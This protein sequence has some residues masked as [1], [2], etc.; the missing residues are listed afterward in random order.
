MKKAFTLA[1]LLVVLA[2]LGVIAAIVTPVVFD[3]MPNE[4]M[5][6]FKKAYYTFEKA[7]QTL[8]NDTNLYPEV[9]VFTNSNQDYF[10]NNL[11]NLLNTASLG[12]NNPSNCSGST[13]TM[14]TASAL[15]DGSP[16]DP[17]P[18]NPN[19]EATGGTCGD[20]N[21]ATPAFITSDGV[22]WWGLRSTFNPDKSYYTVVCI[23]VDGKG[24][25]TAI[26]VGLRYDGK[27]RL[28][29]RASNYLRGNGNNL[30]ME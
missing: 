4:N 16:A 6:R 20:A 5:I 17:T 3:A 24:G 18:E 23:D 11:A 15:N 21:S 7:V 19:P 29:N 8:A 25:E 27:I 14:Q 12:G 10:C 2:V 22:W 30:L 1:E 28:S 13:A 26:P 9:T